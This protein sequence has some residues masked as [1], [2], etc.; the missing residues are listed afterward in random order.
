M[1]RVVVR[2]TVKPGRAEEN[3]A[4]VREVYAEL[5]RTEPV[6]LRYATYQL[7]D[8]ITFV[9]VAEHETGTDSNPLTSLGAFKRFQAE[10][11]DRCEEGPIVSE[12]EEVGSYRF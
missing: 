9:H 11:R 4:L 12:A 6:G 1:R 5:A 2:Y 7:E 8:G 10:L 3:A